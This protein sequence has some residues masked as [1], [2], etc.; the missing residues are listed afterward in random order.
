MKDMVLL[1]LNQIPKYF[2]NFISILV[3]PKSFVRGRNDTSQ[4]TLAEAMT[5]YGISFVITMILSWPLMP[6]HVESARFLATRALTNL[7]VV[8]IG[9]A[10]TLVSWRFVGGRAQFASYFVIGC[11]YV[12]VLIVFMMLVFLCALGVVKI[13][14]PALYPILA[15]SSA[16][17]QIVNEKLNALINDPGNRK[18]LNVFLIYNLI[19]LIGMAAML[20]WSILGWGAF[21]EINGLTKMRSFVAGIIAFLFTLIE[22]PIVFVI[23]YVMD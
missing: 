5:F 13:L 8:T 19:F 7:I 15:E 20:F 12:G 21:R 2:S 6:V 9:A 17:I 10:L 23:Q 3:G 4:Q 11:Y 16:H 1:V 22:L 14:D 18:H